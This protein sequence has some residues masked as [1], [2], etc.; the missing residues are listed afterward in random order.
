[1]LLRHAWKELVAE[2]R[3][4]FLF[5]LNLALGLSGLVTMEAFRSSLS[6]SLRAN[7]RSLLAA[8]LSVSSRR[9]LRAEE[10]TL[11]KE[12]GREAVGQS[13][14]VETFSM[15]RTPAASRLVSLRGLGEGYPL[16]GF[17]SLHRRG[18]VSE[19]EAHSLL[20]SDRIW[21]D[22]DLARQL[23]TS[24]GD[25]IT[26]GSAE[27]IVD[28][29][30][31][32]DPTMSF[33][34]L[35][36]A[37][38]ILLSTE[39]LERTGLVRPES[40]VSF[41]NLFRLKDEVDSTAVSETWAKRFPDSAIRVKAAGEAAEDSTRM[42]GYLGDFLGLSALVALFLS[43]LG[44]AYLFR[45]WLVKRSRVFAVH[46][47]LGLRFW[48]AAAIPGIQALLLASISVPFA[49]VLGKAE[50][51]AL[52]LLIRNLSPVEIPVALSLSSVG[53]S[54]AVAAGGSIL[55]ALPFLVSLR[56]IDTRDLLGGKIPEPKFSPQALTFFLPAGAL[57]YGLSVYEAQSFR[58]AGIFVAALLGATL[59][60]LGAGLVF[61]KLL[62]FLASRWKNAP[63]PLRQ[64][65]LQLSRRGLNSL[66]AFVA[67]ALGALLLN[68]LPQLRFS[69]MAELENPEAGK[70]PS[71][72]LF[73]IQDDQIDALTK[74]LEAK[75][76]TLENRSP[77]VRARLLQVNELTFEKGQSEEGFRTREEENE[78]RFRNRGFNLSYRSALTEAE[79]I[80][81][82]K[83]F[84]PEPTEIN[85]ISVEQRFAGRVG[86]KI[87]DLLLF[88][89]QGVEV[90]GKIV[91]LRTVKWTTFQPN[92]FVLFQDGPLND[93]P[94]IFLG[95]L[96]DL[97]AKE[98]DDLQSELA[99]EFPNVSVV[100]VRSTVTRGLEL[101]DRMRWSLNLM[102]LISL[103]AGFVVLFSIANRQ[104][105]LRRWDINLCKVL[106]AGLAG[107]RLQQ[108]SEFGL[109]SF[110]A[111]CFGAGISILITWIASFYLFEGVF[112]VDPWPLLFS[113]I[114]T[115]LLALF[116]SWLGARHVWGRSPAELL[117]DQPL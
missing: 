112:R 57:L 117:Q 30:V 74:M 97:P 26:L 85:E 106:G 40:T 50:L 116:V 78:A 95:S 115:T 63:W 54:F 33:R 103:F 42:L 53:I 28:D 90:K 72:F 1:M 59:A 76:L 44:S 23:N 43:T 73:D 111:G 11:V 113:V 96:K 77:M 49:L 55:L 79:E 46:Q 82:G 84:S 24:I 60:F 15:V 48:E 27:F 109:L 92:F 38:R 19:G 80:V 107:I 14:L 29:F 6:D 52:S 64:A 75:G 83:P 35:A 93:A 32:F 105:E 12:I 67:L 56:S 68:L 89:V 39:G 65:F 5:L 101:A 58:T 102:S 108:L 51:L 98:K 22:P 16:R 62:G 100:D 4:A 10:L 88:D 71:L 3:F 18:K 7:A 94:K 37:G 81:E 99:G 41:V 47:V 114:G 70:L 110:A 34:A 2:P 91:N 9:P 8:D 69:L 25:R 104:A 87:G 21:L 66:S 86:L 17:M 36:L 45:T 13:K 31:S 61:L 20:G